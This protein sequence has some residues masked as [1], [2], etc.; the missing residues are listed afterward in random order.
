MTEPRLCPVADCPETPEG[1][2]HFCIRHWK[3]VPPAMREA[4]F[5]AW[6]RNDVPAIHEGFDLAVRF[7]D[8]IERLE[9]A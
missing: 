2:A 4:L 8:L 5:V 9:A 6:D 7:V 3:V 1:D